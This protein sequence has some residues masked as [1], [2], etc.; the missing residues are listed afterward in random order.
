[1][2]PLRFT[3]FL[4]PNMLR[5]YQRVVEYVGQQLHIPT[6][7]RVARSRATFEHGEMDVAFICGLPYVRLAQRAPELTTPLAAPVLQGERF[8]DRPIYF[9]DVI[10]RRDS[11]FTTFAD[12]RGQR[13]AFNVDD[14]QSGYGITRHTLLLMGE[15]HGYFSEVIAAGWHEVA[16]R[17]V[18]AG[19]VDASAID[20]QTLAIEFRDHPELAEQLRVIAA[21]GPSTIQPVVAAARLSRSL[22][23]DI[24]A[25]LLAMGRDDD[26]RAALDDGF[27]AHFSVITDS[28]Y[29]DIRAMESAAL[30]ARFMTLR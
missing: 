15:T 4:A 25:A 19:K 24:R 7:L 26:A 30:S 21:L 16:I 22:R 27:I 20:A 10:V 6:D 12:L 8:H 17:M 11:L 5:V 18:A 23:E 28:D 1:M 9:S 14:S 13:W 29:D 3:T 2:E